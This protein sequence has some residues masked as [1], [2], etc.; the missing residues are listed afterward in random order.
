MYND[1]ELNEKINEALKRLRERA[2]QQP[3]SYKM[4]FD[5]AM[6]IASAQFQRAILAEAIL[7]KLGHTPS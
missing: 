2:T 6:E 3:I 5:E 7:H 1:K 4:L